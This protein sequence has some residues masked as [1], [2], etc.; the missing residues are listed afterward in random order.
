MILDMNREQ[1]MD[2]NNMNDEYN[3]NI[4]MMMNMNNDYKT[5]N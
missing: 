1:N 4:Y 3:M 5:N 2:M